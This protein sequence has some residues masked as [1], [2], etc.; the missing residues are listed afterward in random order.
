MRRLNNLQELKHS[1]GRARAFAEDLTM[2]QLA[3]YI[4]HTIGTIQDEIQTLE[5]SLEPKPPA[6]E[7]VK[8]RTTKSSPSTNSPKETQ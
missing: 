4:S 2:L 7:T 8:R 1:L 5:K 3:T 6:K